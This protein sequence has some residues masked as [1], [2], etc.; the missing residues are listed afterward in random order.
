[1]GGWWWVVSEGPEVINPN[2]H[3][4]PPTSHALGGVS[5]LKLQWIR[6]DADCHSRIAPFL[7]QTP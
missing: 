1:V 4:A 6:V 7:D 3:A 5:H 2:P